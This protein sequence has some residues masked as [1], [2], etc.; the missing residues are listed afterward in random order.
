MSNHIFLCPCGCF[1]SNSLFY[2]I[3]VCFGKPVS[4]IIDSDIGMCRL[5]LPIS[6]VPIT[7]TNIDTVHVVIA[8]TNIDVYIICGAL[9]CYL[10]LMVINYCL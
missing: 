4:I 10:R 3:Q 8:C 1:E 6:A 2:M 7:D 9:A 5:Q